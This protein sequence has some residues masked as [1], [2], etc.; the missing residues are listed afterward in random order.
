MT[1]RNP[2]ARREPSGK[3]QRAPPDLMSPAEV[4]RLLDAAKAGLRDPVWSSHVGILKAR[5]LIT[6][7][8]FAAARRWLELVAEYAVATQSPRQPKSANLDPKGGT[9]PDPDSATGRREARRHAKT[10]ESYQTARKVLVAIGEA[11]RVAL[12]DVV[13]LDLYPVGAFQLAALRGALSAL[14]ALWGARK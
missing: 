12:R 14:A 1:R 13:E 8:Q 5:G 7:T 10:V 4:R 11:P 6:D 2:L 3:I 9:A